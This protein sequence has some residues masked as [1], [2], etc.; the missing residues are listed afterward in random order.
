M[1]TRRSNS[2]QAS[3]WIILK[4]ITPELSTIYDEVFLFNDCSSNTIK[5]MYTQTHKPSISLCTCNTLN[6]IQSNPIS[7]YNFQFSCFAVV[8]VIILIQFLLLFSFGCDSAKG[9][10]TTKYLCVYYMNVQWRRQWRWWLYEKYWNTY[11]KQKKKQENRKPIIRKQQSKA[12]TPESMYKAM[13][14]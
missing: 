2:E 6:A 11:K 7:S 3:N 1:S 8:V 13:G 9:E 4:K 10:K 14:T 12:Y 5:E